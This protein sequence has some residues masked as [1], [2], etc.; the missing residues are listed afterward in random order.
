[1]KDMACIKP[2]G[3]L[4]L[5]GARRPIAQLGEMALHPQNLDPMVT[6]DVEETFGQCGVLGPS[7]ESR[8]IIRRVFARLDDVRHGFCPGQFSFG[9]FARLLVSDTADVGLIRHS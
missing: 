4:D 6:N 2:P 9:H 1:M 8:K 3:R 7:H 5:A